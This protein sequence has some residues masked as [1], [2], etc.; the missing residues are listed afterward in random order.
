MVN[1]S[2]PC[3]VPST[4]P[5][6]YDGKLKAEN[7]VLSSR[8]FCPTL[9]STLSSPVV[10]V[11]IVQANEWGSEKSERKGKPWHWVRWIGVM[12]TSVREFF[13]GGTGHRRILW[14]RKE[15]WRERASC[16]VF[17][18]LNRIFARASAS[19][20]ISQTLLSVDIQKHICHLP[21]DPVVVLVLIWSCLSFSF[22]HPFSYN[23][24]HSGIKRDNDIGDTE[25]DE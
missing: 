14:M 20:E 11:V 25:L 8:E 10:C 24:V 15:R 12:M 1:L 3:Y 19:E 7:L 21:W 16:Q 18:Q 2:S 23:F 17:Q 5:C 22:A 13:S 9:S 4:L 6:F